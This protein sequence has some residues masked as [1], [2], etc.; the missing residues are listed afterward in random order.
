MNLLQETISKLA[1]YGKTTKDVLWVGDNDVHFTWD[2][3][4]KVANIEYDNGYGGHEIFEDLVIVGDNWWLS[5]GEYDGS[6]WWEFL[7]PPTK[8]SLHFDPKTVRYDPEYKIRYYTKYDGNL[9]SNV[10]RASFKNDEE[11]Y[12]WQRDNKINQ[13]IK[14]DEL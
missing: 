2:E 5:R 9:R 8:P 11:F 10:V 12:I 3:F 1:H 7:T 4:A 13:I 14:G 6:E